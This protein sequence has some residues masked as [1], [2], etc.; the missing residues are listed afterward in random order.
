MLAVSAAAENI[1]KLVERRIA[2]VTKEP[3]GAALFLFVEPRATYIANVPREEMIRVLEGMLIR[4]KGQKGEERPVHEEAA[5]G[6]TVQGMLR[7]DL[8]TVIDGAPLD[9]AEAALSSLVANLICDYAPSPEEAITMVGE[10]HGRLAGVVQQRISA[11]SIGVNLPP[12]G[13]A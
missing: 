2:R 10:L 12:A 6:K 5:A 1:M 11:G 8:A 4:W 9:D 13:T 3:V 7:R